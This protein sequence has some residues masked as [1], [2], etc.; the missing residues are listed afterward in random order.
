LGFLNGPPF[1]RSVGGNLLFGSIPDQRGEM[2]AELARRLREN[3]LSASSTAGLGSVFTAVADRHVKEGGRIA[4][5]LPADY[6]WRRVAPKGATYCAAAARPIAPIA[7]PAMLAARA[8]RPGP[9]P[10]MNGGVG[11]WPYIGV[12][13]FNGLGQS[14]MRHNSHPPRPLT[15]LVL[16]II[17]SSH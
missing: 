5:V 16:V 4:L 1:V 6:D 14:L 11:I 8:P 2:Q 15:L 10:G 9:D 17:D 3:D 12:N 13:Y 7:R